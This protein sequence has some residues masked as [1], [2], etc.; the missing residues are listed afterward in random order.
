MLEVDCLYCTTTTKMKQLMRR[1]LH[2]PLMI[3][4]NRDACYPSVTCKYDIPAIYRHGIY[5]FA[6]L[7]RVRLSV[8][9]VE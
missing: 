2:A 4:R 5:D 6:G 3:A 9:D 8:S 7:F 1:T